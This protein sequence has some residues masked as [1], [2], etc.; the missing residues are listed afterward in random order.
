MSENLNVTEKLAILESAGVDLSADPPQ[1][2]VVN[3]GTIQP[4]PVSWL[5]HPYIPADKITLMQGDPG[6]GKTFLSL[7]IASIISRGGKFFGEDHLISR[8]PG[9]VIFQTAEDGVADTLVPR[10]KKMGANMDNIYFIEEDDTA[11]SFKDTRLEAAIAELRPR[12]IVFDPIQAF[13]G[14]E[15]DLHRANEIRPLMKHLG[16]LAERYTCAVVLIM[17]M[18]KASG[19]K[20]IYRGLGSIDIPAAA[21]SMLVVGENSDDP[22]EKIMAHGKSSLAKNG[23]SISFRIDNDRGVVFEGW[24][25]LSANEVSNPTKLSGKPKASLDD[26]IDL[27]REA[28]GDQGYAKLEDI[29]AIAADADV[30]ERTLYRARDELALK[31]ISVGFGKAKAAFWFDPD[32]DPEDIKTSLEPR[33]DPQQIQFPR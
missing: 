6:G 5:W 10:L 22:D 7:M 14:A 4:Q 2:L 17:H 12:L 27:L 1:S 16:G 32:T 28:L 26:A 13:L 25:D 19:T 31:T 30:S 9:K 3:M 21:R 18:S 15:V 33:P 29:K 20:A 24:S 11:L 23:Q 8:D